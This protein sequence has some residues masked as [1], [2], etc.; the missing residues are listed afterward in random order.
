MDHLLDRGHRRVAFI[1]GPQDL[2]SSRIRR[3]AFLH[4]MKERGLTEG[5]VETGNHRIDG[6]FSAMSRILAATPAPTAVLCSNDL[7]AIGALRAIRRGGLQVP[8]D[9][10]IIGFDDIL[11]AEF[12]EP[13]L[14]TVR[15][16]REELAG[17]AFEAL[18]ASLRAPKSMGAE[19]TVRTEL[20]IREST[21]SIRTS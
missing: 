4:A 18:L 3:K 9:I 1:S 21:A 7:T 10:S 17:K 11:L 19:Y 8:E 14:T 12:T 5:L 20:V 16:P 6:G 15:L 13:P 2:K